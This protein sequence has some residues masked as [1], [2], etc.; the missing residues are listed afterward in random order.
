MSTP[1]YTNNLIIYHSDDDICIE[2]KFI[3]PIDDTTVTTSSIF[4]TK[5]FAKHLLKYLTKVLNHE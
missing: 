5:K 1:K 3:N 2:F 4:M